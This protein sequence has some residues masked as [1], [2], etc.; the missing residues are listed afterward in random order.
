MSC[1][2][3][4]FITPFLR[5]AAGIKYLRRR[6]LPGRKVI[7]PS[8]FLPRVESL[9]QLAFLQQFVEKGRVLAAVGVCAKEAVIPRA[10]QGFGTDG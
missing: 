5:T 10:E 2:I 4:V 3:V 8:R 6:P 9:P 7:L 1:I